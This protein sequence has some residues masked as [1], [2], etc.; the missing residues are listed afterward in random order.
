VRRTGIL[1]NSDPPT[2]ESVVL[3]GG[4]NRCSWHAG[5]WREGQGPLALAPRQIAAVS[6]A[7]AIAC[8][9]TNTKGDEALR[10]SQGA[11]RANP[12][13]WYPRNLF[14]KDPVFPHER[15]YRAAMRDLFDPPTLAKVHAG[16]D[17]RV[18]LRHLPPWLGPRTGHLTAS[19][20]ASLPRRR[21]PRRRWPSSDWP[22]SPGSGEAE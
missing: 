19:A 22:V 13:N 8:A 5:F 18:L 1:L 4:G 10:L 14:G 12:R 21:S 11:T 15:M 20:P 3:A 16:P 2:F 7:G 6:A 9:I 17:I